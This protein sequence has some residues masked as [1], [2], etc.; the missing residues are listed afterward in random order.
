[1]DPLKDTLLAREAQFAPK[2]DKAVVQSGGGLPTVTP[3]KPAH[4]P[5]AWQ[6]FLTAQKMMMAYRNPNWQP[7][8]MV[9]QA[10]ASK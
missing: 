9:I 8:P 7:N 5:P 3:S 6:R 10:L 2:S 1:M 4:L